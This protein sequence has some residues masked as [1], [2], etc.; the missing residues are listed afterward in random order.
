LAFKQFKSLA[1]FR[2][3]PEHNDTSPY[4]NPNATFDPIHGL[5][6]AREIG[7]ET[8]AVKPAQFGS[9]QTS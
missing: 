3:L 1:Q 5:L 6:M 8:Y 2:H 9:R 7:A 4:Q